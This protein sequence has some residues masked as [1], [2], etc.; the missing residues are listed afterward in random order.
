MFRIISLFLVCVF[1]YA[2]AFAQK[3]NTLRLVI[4]T[5]EDGVF[6]LLN[7]NVYSAQKLSRFDTLFIPKEFD[8]ISFVYKDSPTIVR[9]SDWVYSRSKILDGMYTSELNILKSIEIPRNN[10]YYLLENAG[11]NVFLQVAPD[12]QA[13]FDGHEYGPGDYHLQLPKAKYH[14]VTKNLKTG[15]SKKYTLKIS[16]ELEQVH[17][18][19]SS[20]P[21]KIFYNS[22]SLVPGLSQIS[23]KQRAKGTMMFVGFVALATSSIRLNNTYNNKLDQYNATKL[24]YGISTSYAEATEL[25]NRMQTLS[26]ESRKA[27][28][29]LAV[30][31]SALIGLYSY[32]IVDARKNAKNFDFYVK[33]G[34]KASAG[35]IVRF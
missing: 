13:L 30:S 20:H 14:L 23:L 21:S 31:F 22:L 28:I 33:P 2:G 27:R 7:D 5:Q 34:D 6:F 29:Q 10:L 35:V 32:H 1:S 9:L 12:E 18:P 3:S 8:K 11:N 24:S 17:I 4:S 19:V 25:G 15:L 26:D 16:N